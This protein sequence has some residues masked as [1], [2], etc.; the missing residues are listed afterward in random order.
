MAHS[1]LDRAQYDRGARAAAEAP[2]EEGSDEASA[3]PESMAE[4]VPFRPLPSC[5]FAPAVQ[6]RALPSPPP[7]DVA[8]LAGELLRSLQVGSAR[9]RAQVRLVLGGGRGQSDLEVTL[10]ETETG[11]MATLDAGGGGVETERLMRALEREL[12]RRSI[13]VDCVAR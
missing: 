6:A 13:S 9:G 1:A 11:V 2:A 5:V 8:Q 3:P 7:A 10:E 12:A 4:G